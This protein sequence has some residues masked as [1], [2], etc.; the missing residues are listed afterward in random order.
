MDL[1]R[2]VSLARAGMLRRIGS[3]RSKSKKSVEL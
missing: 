2:Q 1:R 3:G